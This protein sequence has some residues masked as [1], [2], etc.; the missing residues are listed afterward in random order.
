M[1]FPLLGIPMFSGNHVH[2][3]IVL[4]ATFVLT[5]PVAALSYAL[6]EEPARV[7]INKMWAKYTASTTASSAS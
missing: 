5:V 2:T 1:V 6:V 7:G 3:V 4:I